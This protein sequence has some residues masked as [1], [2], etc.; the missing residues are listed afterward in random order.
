MKTIPESD[1]SQQRRKEESLSLLPLDV[2]SVIWQGKSWALCLSR[3]VY[4]A[5]TNY[6]G[7]YKQ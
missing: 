6:K 7:N 2:S 3:S 5:I 4:E 1:F